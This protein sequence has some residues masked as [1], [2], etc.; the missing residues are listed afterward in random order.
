MKYIVAANYSMFNHYLRNFEE[1]NKNCKFVSDIDHI[2]GVSKYVVVVLYEN[3]WDN[4]N[5]YKMIP[6][7]KLFE[8]CWELKQLRNE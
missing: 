2:R 4:P 1:N 7:L 5:L 3:Y 8:N 6:Y